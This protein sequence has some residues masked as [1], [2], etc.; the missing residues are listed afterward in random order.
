MCRVS[1]RA[2][3]SP[4]SPGVPTDRRPPSVVYVGTTACTVPALNVLLPLPG[5]IGRKVVFPAVGSIREM[6]GNASR[7]ERIFAQ[8]KHRN[9]AQAAAG[10]QPA[11]AVTRQRWPIWPSVA[12]GAPYG[13]PPR[14]TSQEKSQGVDRG[15]VCCRPP[16]SGRVSKQRSMPSLAT[17]R[18]RGRLVPAWPRH[19][20]RFARGDARYI[21][22]RLIL[23]RGWRAR[24]ARPVRR[25]PSPRR[26]DGPYPPPR[27]SPGL[28]SIASHVLRTNPKHLRAS[29]KE[30]GP[31]GVDDACKCLSL[32]RL[33]QRESWWI[34]RFSPE[35][36]QET[37]GKT[38]QALLRPIAD[39]HGPAVE[40][41]NSA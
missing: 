28:M 1:T 41:R 6:G 2:L 5:C 30:C 34:F 39:P 14:K 13:L 8:P 22:A 33:R 19:A 29:V 26:G 36:A 17:F 25:S 21:C 27:K 24:S 3:A 4:C 18:L 9:R 12:G 35:Q 40:E 32:A 7:W 20:T 10:I 38:R 37:M 23:R 16:P 15:T 31:P 11:P